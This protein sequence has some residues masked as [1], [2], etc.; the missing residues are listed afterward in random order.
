MEDSGGLPGYESILDAL[1]DSTHPDHI[2]CLEWAAAVT[3]SNEPFDPDRLD[4]AEVN[5]KLAS[6]GS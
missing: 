4:I 5:R 3:D 1:A 2:E 6:R